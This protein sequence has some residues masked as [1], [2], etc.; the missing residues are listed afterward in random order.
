[1]GYLD[2]ILGLF[3]VGPNVFTGGLGL[4]EGG[5]WGLFKVGLDSNYG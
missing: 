3:G 5:G 4:I 2:V 1:M